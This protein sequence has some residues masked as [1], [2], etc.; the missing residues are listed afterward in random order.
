MNFLHGMMDIPSH[1]MDTKAILQLTE[2]YKS[3]NGRIYRG[4]FELNETF[5]TKD[6][7]SKE[8]EVSYGYIGL[9]YD[10]VCKAF[11]QTISIWGR[12]KNGDY[13][14]WGDTNF[15]RGT[16]W[17]ARRL[18]MR[19]NE[20]HN[21]CGVV[22]VAWRK[23]IKR[24]SEKMFNEETEKYRQAF[25]NDDPKVHDQIRAAILDSMY[26]PVCFRC[27]NEKT[28]GHACA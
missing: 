4:R 2:E 28:E 21:L 24:V 9:E 25:L 20:V 22:I 11:Y 8:C 14:K 5:T 18:M 16:S 10:R 15:M 7:F 13:Y 17:H 6:H 12:Y 23:N 3:Y 26:K 19:L 27:L 1:W